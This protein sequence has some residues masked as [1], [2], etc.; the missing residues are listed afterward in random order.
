MQEK[1]LSF[2]TSLI[3]AHNKVLDFFSVRK[4][5]VEQRN[6]TEFDFEATSILEK[7]RRRLLKIRGKRDHRRRSRGRGGRGVRS[8]PNKNLGA[9]PH[10]LVL[11]NTKINLTINL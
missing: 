5:T 8:P 3:S 10:V 2:T 9:L 6:K 4:K 7:A 11:K 1:C